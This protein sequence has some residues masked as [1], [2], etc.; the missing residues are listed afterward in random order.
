MTHEQIRELLALRLYGEIDSEEEQRILE[1]L[2]EC[3][4]CASF[5]RELE[6]GLGRV[7]DLHSSAEL[8][9]EWDTHLADTT[10]ALHRA[11]WARSALLVCAGLAAGV[12]LML[13]RGSFSRSHA[14]AP[15]VANANPDAPAFLR[16]QGNTPPPLATAGGPATRYLAWQAR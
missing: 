4:A 1:H 2:R 11:S 9:L 3:R 13:A 16:F 14:V 15:L 12:L 7:R 8:P 10:A 5:A 6:Q